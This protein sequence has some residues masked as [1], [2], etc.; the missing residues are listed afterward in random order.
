[1][2][3]GPGPG[4]GSAVSRPLEKERHMAGMEIKNIEKP[5]ETRKFKAHGWAEVVQL[6]GLTFLRGTFQ[7]GWEWSHDVKPIAGTDSCQVAHNG[8]VVSGRMRVTMA[9]DGSS[10]EIG[11]GD[12]FTIAPG[13]D[14]KTLGD[15]D[16]VMYDFSSAASAYAT[17]K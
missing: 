13:H 10:Y 15:E 12:I 1:M 2:E 7:P 8:Y 5:D 9:A 6:P 3:T 4:P 16:C 17:P 11:P 14:A